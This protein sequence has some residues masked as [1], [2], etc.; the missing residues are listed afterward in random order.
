MRAENKVEGV[1]SRDSDDAGGPRPAGLVPGYPWWL[2][3]QPGLGR[4]TLL[5]ERKLK[6]EGDLLMASPKVL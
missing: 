4:E 6:R 3:E 5:M 1:I 2:C